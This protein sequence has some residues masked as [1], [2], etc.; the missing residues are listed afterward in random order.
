MPRQNGRLFQTTSWNTFSW[1]RMFEFRY[2]SLKFGPKGQIKNIPALVPIMAWRLPGDKSLSEPLMFSLLT[3]ICVT[4]P[5]IVNTKYITYYISW[6]V[7]R[8]VVF[9]SRAQDLLLEYDFENHHR[10]KSHDIWL[11]LQLY[12]GP[13]PGLPYLETYWLTKGT[14][15]TDQL[16][17]NAWVRM[18]GGGAH[19]LSR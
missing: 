7:H 10:F 14:P 18:A 4:G 13:T 17:L 19:N 2:S 11:I 8:V 6:E 16:T 1:M 3:Q 9:S 15:T 12:L 5:H